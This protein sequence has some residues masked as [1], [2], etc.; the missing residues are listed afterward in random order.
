MMPE[1]KQGAAVPMVRT[2]KNPFVF[3]VG[4]PRSGTTLLQRMLN[5]HPQLAVINDSHFVARVPEKHAPETLEAATAGQSLPLSP[6]LISGTQEYHRTWR[7][8]LDNARLEQIAASQ[9]DWS[10]FVAAVFDAVAAE[11]GKPLAGE[12]TP[13]YVR[14]L[15]LLHGLFPQARVVHIVRDGRD[16]AL[17]L[18]DWAHEKKGPGRLEMWQRNPVA[19]AAIWW[20]WLVESGRL[21]ARRLPD[22]AYLEVRYETLV[23]EPEST[24]RGVADFLGLDFSPRMLEFH[25]GRRRREAKSAKSA[26][27]PPTR[28]LRDWRKQLSSGQQRVFELLAG[29]CLEAGG[30]ECTHGIPS[31]TE[32]R[33]AAELSAWWKKHR[34]K[35]HR[36]LQARAAAAREGSAAAG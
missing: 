13:D 35:E 27:L 19:V 2:S 36:K 20:R 22:L 33:R 32:L 10:G 30:Y 23:Q 16:V 18:R 3:V 26:W 6:A 25:A 29:D 4:C 12:K 34:R 14:N 11:N 15:P 7:V 5:S 17:S 24:L 8:G 28:G 9:T 1:E 31:D 21:A